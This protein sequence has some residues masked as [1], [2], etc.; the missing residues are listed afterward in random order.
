MRY[1]IG[2]LITIGLIVLLIILLVH[3]G[4]NKSKL[5]NSSKT[6]DSYAGTDA[7]VRLTIDESIVA[8]QEHH[9]EQIT[10]GRDQVTYEQITGYDGK[11][12]KS[13]TYANTESSYSTF[14]HALDHA[15]FTKGN[16]ASN[17]KDE[18]GYCPLGQ[19]YIFELIDNGDDVERF[20]STNCSG[21]K[22]F[23]GNT[24]LNL[25]LFQKQVPDYN[26]LTNEN[27]SLSSLVL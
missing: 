19:R 14:L 2:F 4:G 11:V 25:Q 15:G 10:V 7:T 24:S 22:S 21:P 17:L 13:Q 9:A 23:L 16:T 12:T 1:F 6:L 26:K 18:R 8:Q 3:G 5:P 20:W 27:G